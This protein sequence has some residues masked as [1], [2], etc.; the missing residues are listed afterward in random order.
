MTRF[1]KLFL[2][3]SL[4]SA[5]ACAAAYAQAT[6]SLRGSVVDLRGESTAWMYI[7]LRNTDT[8][9]ERFQ[10]AD[11]KGAFAFDGLE[12][13]R[14]VIVTSR[15]GIERILREVKIE[16]GKAAQIELVG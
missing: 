7:T 9:R 16:P 14:Y 2:A 5:I 8:G 3:A 11:V 1:I 6:G 13:G 10:S 4:L 12:P 15:P